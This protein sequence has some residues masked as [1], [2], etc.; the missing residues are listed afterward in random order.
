MGQLLL[1]V[2]VALT[3][4]AVVFGVTVLVSGND[5]GLAP[6]E[7]D[8]RS[9]PLPSTRPLQEDDLDAVRFDTG[10]RGYRMVQVDKALKRAAYDIGY[11][12]ELI[13]VLEAEVV[14]L[15]EGR[16]LDAD[17]LRRAREA[18]QLPAGAP[19]AEGEET[20]G[21]SAGTRVGAAAGAAG[22]A[23]GAGGAAT[24]TLVADEADRPAE[25]AAEPAEPAA[26]PAEPVAEPVAEPAEPAAGPDG[27]PGPVEPDGPEPDLSGIEVVAGP[28]VDPEPE[29]LLEPAS[30]AEVDAPAEVLAQEP[31]GAEV[32]GDEPVVADVVLVEEVSAEEPVVVADEEPTGEPAAEPGD[33][34]AAAEA[35]DKP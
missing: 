26:E 1:I 13:G 32:P 16:T 19:A 4:A 22:G 7:P 33:G 12:D 24:A 17:A 14:A 8:G 10:L 3:I 2:V 23:A 20:P 34:P 30:G 27:E 9:V 25:P 11:K 6:A 35:R 31:S 28:A 21:A 5:G 29:P 15:R 18:A